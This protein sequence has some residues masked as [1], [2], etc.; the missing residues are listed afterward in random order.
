MRRSGC[1]GTRMETKRPRFPPETELPRQPASEPTI[2]TH[3]NSTRRRTRDDVHP[4]KGRAATR[5]RPGRGL[6]PRLAVTTSTEP[7]Q[8]VSPEWMHTQTMTSAS[9][10]R[11]QRQGAG[12]C[13]LLRRRHGAAV[14]GAACTPDA[15][16][17]QRS[18]LPRSD[19]LAIGLPVFRKTL[20]DDRVDK[21]RCERLHRRDR[22]WFP[23]ENRGDEARRRFALERLLSGE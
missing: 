7:R 15:V 8:A 3:R 17:R 18:A 19:A 22:G 16:G 6:A 11:R 14:F 5:T 4:V 2:E 20:P 12:P 21:P 13:A 1:L 9:M 23:L 10:G